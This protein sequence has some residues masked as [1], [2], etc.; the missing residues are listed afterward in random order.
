[1]KILVGQLNFTVGAV[2]ANVDK[3]CRSVSAAKQ[4]GVDL[5]VF[6]ELA[7][8]GYPPED[9]LLRDD[10]LAL[11]ERELARLS[12]YA[13]GIA[14]VVGCPRMTLTG[15]RNAAVVLTERQIKTEYYKHELP[16]YGVFDEARYFVKGT[17]PCVFRL[18][19]D[20][21][22]I[23]L[24]ICED[25]WFRT[26][27]LKARAA[28]AELLISIHASPF[29]M[30][31]EPERQS[32][33]RRCSQLTDLPHLC[34]Q[35]VG[36]QDDLAFD[37]GSKA[38]GVNGG[39]SF[40]AP[41]FTESEAIVVY[42]AKRQCFDGDCASE[43]SE[44]AKVYQALVL[45]IKDYV[46]KNGFKHVFIGLS[47]GL[48]SSLTLALAVDALG[49]ERVT[50]VMMPSRF[51]S[52]ASN[53]ALRWQLTDVPV[54][55]HTLSIEPL[56]QTALTTLNPSFEK[57]EWD[58]TEENLQARCRGLLLMALANKY[59]G[60]V[61]N[62]SNKSEMAVGYSTLYGD[63]VGGFAALKDVPKTYVVKLAEYRNTLSATIPTF[64]IERP[65][66]AELALNQKDEDSLP[67]YAVLDEC[68]AR[69]VDQRQSIDDIVA[70]GFERTLVTRIVKLILI[71]EYKRRQ[72]PPGIKITRQAFTRE[73]R[74]PMTAGVW[75]T[76]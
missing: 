62:T 18:S 43:L 15:L 64:I 71:N 26:P 27:A 36:A 4:A 39:I 53:E 75:A 48:D 20:G 28:G 58:K 31:K 32:V 37:G 63:M 59:N 3:M 56:F 33:Y 66:S 35:T 50:A 51:T 38:F 24:L 44:I 7:L 52:E 41:Y 22:L 16:N 17:E 1:M 76:Q 30:N 23:G 21:P 2:V 57:T 47:G 60:L 25:T 49:L 8:C 11:C 74:F 46:N 69:F 73:R 61:L 65:P 6:P 54:K 55:T 70:A 67:S 13:D 34:C 10:F 45:G 19:A 72:S 40:A 42:D 12:T 14:I 68:I 5:V 9:L 29:A